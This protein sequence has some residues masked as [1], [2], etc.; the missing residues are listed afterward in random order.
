MS[1]TRLRYHLVMATENRQQLLTPEVNTILYPALQNK[2]L[3]N[4]GKLLKIGGRKEHVHMVAVIPPTIA[5]MDFMGELKTGSSRAINKSDLIKGEFNWQKGYGALTLNPIELGAVLRYVADQETH[6][7]KGPLWID[8]ERVRCEL[9]EL[10][11]S[12]DMAN[13]SQ[14][15]YTRLRY[16]LVTA[17]KTREMLLTPPVE[18]ILYP[19]LHKK[20]LKIGCPLLE[21]NGGKDHIHLV[22]AIHPTI[23]VANFMRTVKAG[24]SGAI[25]KSR[26]VKKK[27]HWQKG[28]GAFTLEPFNLNGIRHY[29]INQKEHHKAKD[30][31]SAYEK[32]TGDSR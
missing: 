27:F 6:H 22:A 28:Y 3:D 10:S 32:M 5:V 17:T 1:Y 25:N 8:Y 30:L 4:G 2:A 16:H 29:V 15:S 7:K 14:M 9:T 31:W 18:A 19:A 11:V 21:A 13:E 24:S 23:T 12:E 26:L 20:A